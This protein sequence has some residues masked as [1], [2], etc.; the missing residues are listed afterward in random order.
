MELNESEGGISMRKFVKMKY[1]GDGRV[2]Y[3]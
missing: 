2:G 1:H 3:G